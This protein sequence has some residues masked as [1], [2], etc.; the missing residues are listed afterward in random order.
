MIE[1]TNT[2]EATVLVA[3]VPH[4]YMEIAG[5]TDDIRRKR[6][7]LIP[8]MDEVKQFTHFRDTGDDAGIKPSLRNYFCKLLEAQNVLCV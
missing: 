1:V 2:V 6:L 4:K 7:E 3:G 8:E 5:L